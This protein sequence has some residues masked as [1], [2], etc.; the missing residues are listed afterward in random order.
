MLAESLLLAVT[1]GV[2]ASVIAYGE[3]M[4]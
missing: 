2:L 3:S 4:S 1:G